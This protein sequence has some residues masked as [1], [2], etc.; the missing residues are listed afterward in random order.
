ML[1]V[2]HLYNFSYEE[3]EQHVAD[4]LVLR[5][6][7]RVYFHT[8]PD[9]T[10]LCR[11]AR[12]IQSATLEAA[13]D[14]MLSLVVAAKL[15]RSRKLRIDGMVVERRSWLV[16]SSPT[17]TSF[18]VT[19]CASLLSLAIKCGWAR[20]RADSSLSTGC[21]MAIQLTSDSGSP[22]SGV[23]YSSSVIHRGK[24]ALTVA[25][26]LAIMS[27]LLPTWALSVSSCPNL[28]ASRKS[29]ALMKATLV[30]TRSALPR[31]RGRTH[32]RHLT[33]ARPRPLSQSWPDWLRAVGR[34]GRDHQQPDRAGSRA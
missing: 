12:L 29:D 4:S 25:C 20:W 16:S 31:W 8:V 10:T 27:A 9:H 28:A 30:P 7:C 15:T 5:Q 18:A 13:N 34:L 22:P 26:T 33:P 6:F 11:W 24:P 32:Q 17:V 21:L 14:R 3:T 2:K 19:N 1:A 23:T